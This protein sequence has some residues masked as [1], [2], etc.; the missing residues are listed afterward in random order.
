MNLK[1]LSNSIGLLT[2]LEHLDLSDYE[3]LTTLPNSIGGLVGLKIMFLSICSNL[4]EIPMELGRLKNLEE[5]H[6]SCFEEFD[7]SLCGNKNI[8]LP[9]VG[10][11]NKLKNLKMQKKCP[12]GL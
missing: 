1:T 2:E 12:C 6:V 9:N 7:M 11:L 8:S 3:N 10:E 5:L 4:K